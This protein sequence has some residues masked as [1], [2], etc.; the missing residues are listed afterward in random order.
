MADEDRRKRLKTMKARKEA[1]E[2]GEKPVLKF[3]NYQPQTEA[4][5]EHKLAPVEL[6]AVEEAVEEVLA[7]GA[8]VDGGALNIAPKKPDW[9][10]KRDV[11]K[12]TAK[13][14]KRT[15]RAIVELIRRRLEEEA[16]E[17]SSGGEEEAA[18]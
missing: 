18:E 11:Q 3:R 2:A 15:Q 13:L 7:Q 17:A 6:P 4:L 12:R 10:L 5:K 9:D 1:V 16:Q 8:A 14:H